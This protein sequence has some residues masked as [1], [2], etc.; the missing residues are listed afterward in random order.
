[1]AEADD[2]APLTAPAPTRLS[3]LIDSWF[4]EHF[5]G[6]PAMRD[7]ENFNHV[8]RSVDVLKQRLEQEPSQ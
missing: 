3:I 5:H 1:M 8:R 6:H 4:A 2:E 7:T